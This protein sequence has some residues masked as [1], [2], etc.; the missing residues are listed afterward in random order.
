LKKGYRILFFT[1]G[2]AVFIYFILDFGINNL[3]TNIL[4]TGFWLIPVIL[5]W[6]VIYI[7][8]TR[9]WQLI[10]ENYGKHIS[11]LKLLKIHISSS[12]INYVTPLLSLG[13][14][15]YRVISTNEYIEPN[16]SI[17]STLIFNF[18]H[19]LSHLFYW[20]VCSLLTIFILNN[21]TLRYFS[22]I[23]LFILGLIIFVIITGQKKGVFYCVEKIIPDIKIFGFAHKFFSKKSDRFREID[24]LISSYYVGNKKSYASAFLFEFIARCVS[25]MEFYF[26]LMSIG[27]DITIFQSMYIYAAS[28]LILNILFFVPLETGTREASLYYIANTL[29][30]SSGIGIY[31]SV[32]NRIREF[33][34]ILVGLVLIQFNK[35]KELNLKTNQ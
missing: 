11:Y 31:I 34:W 8:N 1:A 22:V 6:L 35:K 29:N 33:F 4:K 26:I 9:A 17:S 20:F 24:R 23:L 21:N 2:L 12:A 15:P 32:V 5:V 19:I 16:V 7:L 10:I 18:V 13:G 3:I 30:L 27:Y 14:E 28:S 25:A